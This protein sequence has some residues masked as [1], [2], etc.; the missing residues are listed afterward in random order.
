VRPFVRSIF[1]RHV[2]ALRGVTAGG[3]W[4]DDGA[5]RLSLWLALDEL[6]AHHLQIDPQTNGNLARMQQMELRLLTW[7]DAHAFKADETDYSADAAGAVL[8]ILDQQRSV[9]VMQSEAI[10]AQKAE[11]ERQR[12]CISMQAGDM[13]RMS[14]QIADLMA[15]LAQL[16]TVAMAPTYTV[17][18]HGPTTAA[19]AIEHIDGSI[20][21]SRETGTPTALAPTLPPVRINWLG[22]P[23]DLQAQILRLEDGTATWRSLPQ[24]DRRAIT[25]YAIP[26]VGGPTISMAEWQE[27]RPG[28]MPTASALASMFGLR[29]SEL[30]AQA[31]RVAEGV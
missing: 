15:E 16:R 14:E 25:L 10:T 8:E 1:D 22:L 4:I 7:L 13:A 3:T 2:T 24:P 31:H 17:N 20:T 12:T 11:I 6:D 28:W 29:W 5:A 21:V 26:R 9:I 23:H 27:C 18:G 30:V 19:V